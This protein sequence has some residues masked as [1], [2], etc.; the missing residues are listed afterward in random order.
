MDRQMGH[1]WTAVSL[2]ALIL[3]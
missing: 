2:N 3:A 1:R